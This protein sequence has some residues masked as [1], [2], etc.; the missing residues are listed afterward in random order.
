MRE[1]CANPEGRQAVVQEA[2]QDGEL[3][4]ALLDQL[5]TGI[6]IV[7]RDRRILYWNG[8]AERIT[9]YLAHEVAG[10]FCHGDLLMHCDAE[11][12][13]L[14][15]TRCP[16]LHVMQD[17]KPRE[18]T[19]FLRHRQGHRL[20][21][22]VRS[23]PIHNSNGEIVGAVEVFEEALAPARHAI[24]ELQVFGCLDDLTGAANRRY[25]EMRVGQAL[26][27]LNEFGI[28]FGWLR[29][30]LDS[31]ERLERR[32]GHGLIDA[33]MKMLFGTLDGNLGSFDVL[34]RW[35]K[36]EFRVEV[37]YSARLALAEIAEKLVVLVRASALE[38]WGDRLRLTVS[39]GAG[40]AEPGD[41][42]ESLEAR[43]AGVFES[44]QAGSGDRATV[45]HAAAPE[46]TPSLP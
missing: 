46:R 32:Y 2:L 14:C 6:Y 25:G 45:A 7:D 19:V 26:E 17:S 35:S 34:T 41:T 30:G 5:D 1:G 38:W 27:A 33:A 18:C 43:V 22:H 8:G 28:P 23:R 16:L 10:H 37:H 40:R 13:V 29:I 42:L 12:A 39:I 15:G 44:C 36:A 20:P 4:K 9:G 11:G 24:R 31:T 21:V 3:H